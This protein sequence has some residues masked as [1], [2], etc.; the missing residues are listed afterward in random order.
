[1]ARNAHRGAGR[2]AGG[3]EGDSIPFHSRPTIPPALIAGP[4]RTR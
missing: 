1:M 4:Y 2:G 3:G